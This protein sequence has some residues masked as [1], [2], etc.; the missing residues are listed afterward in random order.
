MHKYSVIINAMPHYGNRIARSPYGKIIDEIEK[1]EEQKYK[2][3]EYII[4]CNNLTSSY[5]TRHF[6]KRV[7]ANQALQFKNIKWTIK[8]PVDDASDISVIDECFK[9]KKIAPRFCLYLN[10]ERIYSIS[11]KL[12]EYIESK[13][14]PDYWYYDFS[15]IIF[16]P[17]ILCQYFRFGNIKQNLIDA[18]YS[19]KIYIDEHP[20]IG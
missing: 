15:S 19:D 16:F 3:Y 1:L 10:H 9:L 2:P 11:P 12:L 4:I 6:Q 20:N 13:M 5:L 14:T 18:G 7:I 17:T 8:V